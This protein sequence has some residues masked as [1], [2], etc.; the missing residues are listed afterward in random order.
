LDLLALLS[1]GQVVSDL[2]LIILGEA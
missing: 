1:T 2:I